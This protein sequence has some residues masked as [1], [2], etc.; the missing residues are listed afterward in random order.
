MH[1]RAHISGATKGKGG[2]KP[3]PSGKPKEEVTY[4]DSDPSK[5]LPVGLKL[6]GKY[7]GLWHEVVIVEVKTKEAHVPLTFLDL[8][9][10]PPI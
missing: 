6:F 5:P 1:V 3:P 10:L 7:N 4:D 2:E 9:D 8:P